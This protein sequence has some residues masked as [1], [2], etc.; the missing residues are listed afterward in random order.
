MLFEP[1]HCRGF[2]YRFVCDP[3]FRIAF[4][5]RVDLRFALVL[6]P[7]LPHP[8]AVGRALRYERC[9]HV[10]TSAG[11]CASFA[12]GT[13]RREQ[14]SLVWYVFALQSDLAFSKRAVLRDYIRGWRKILFGCVANSAISAGASRLLL[15]P[16]EEVYRA[17]Q[18]AHHGLSQGVPAVWRHIYDGTAKHFGMR[19]TEVEKPVNIQ[20]LPRRTAVQ[21]SLFYQTILHR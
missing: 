15:S 13:S 2:S 8:A 6:S 5:R 18:T 9:R 16:A 4:P 14:G 1:L 7:D 3:K 21:S 17:A 12:L 20:L 11:R 10:R 19:P